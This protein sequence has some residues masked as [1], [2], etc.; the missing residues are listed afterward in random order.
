MTV[1]R[2]ILCRYHGDAYWHERLLLKQADDSGYA[3][4]I[5]TPDGDVYIENFGDVEIFDS[6]RLVPSG[7]G[8]PSGLVGP[9]HPFTMVPSE[10]D[11]RRWTTEAAALV[12]ALPRPAPLPVAPAGG[13]GGTPPVASGEAP[14]DASR[15]ASHPMAKLGKAWMTMCQST[16]GTLAG[17]V[18][19]KDNFVGCHV[20]GKFG[21]FKLDSGGTVPGEEVLSADA[22]QLSVITTTVE[23]AKVGMAAGENW[24]RITGVPASA[25]PEPDARCLAVAK[26]FGTT[27]G[28]DWRSVAAS[29]TEVEME[30]WPIEGPRSSLWVVNFLPKFTD[31]GPESYHRWWRTIC[32]LAMCD[33]GVPE[34]SQICRYLQLGGEWDQLDLGNLALVEAMCRRLQLIEFQYRERA[35]ESRHGGGQGGAAASS[36]TGLVAI[37][38]EESDLFDGVGRMDNVVCVCLQSLWSL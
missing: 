28:R 4:A 29:C 6:V 34:H 20:S 3:W 21:L 24:G 12:P 36:L 1:G 30:D 32:R 10:S 19:L 18:L 7:G 22:H 8:R 11:R 9:I 33:W 5:C 16:C 13:E 26:R 27:R 2:R 14:S 25:E 38:S 37:G 31:Q 35:R 15:W 23:A 17:G